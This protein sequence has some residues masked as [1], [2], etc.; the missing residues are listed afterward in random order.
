VTVRDH[1]TH[2]ESVGAY[3]LGALSD[4]EREAF[5]RHLK[6]CSACRDEV[7]RLRPAADALP[8]SVM[9]VAPPPSLKDSLMET[10][11][12]EAR[13]RAGGREPV[14][15]RLRGRLGRLS[16]ALTRMRPAVAWASAAFILAVGILAGFGI[17]RIG[18]GDDV[19]TIAA[20]VD[21]SRIPFGS[22]SVV[23]SGGGEHGAILRVHGLPDLDSNRVY[24][25][26][27]LRRGEVVPEPTFEVGANGDGAAAVPDDLKGAR[28]VLVTREPRGGSRA[29]SERPL[30]RA[31][32]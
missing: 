23:V 26:W 10:V 28:A 16:P 22:A 18:S 14:A 31:D 30:L 20:K 7:E 25:A 8:R 12:R 3:L 29:P 9:P 24:Q 6:A 27:I 1:D 32:L 19:R 13:E 2:A 5:E 11:Q 4:F 17:T 21:A 15:R